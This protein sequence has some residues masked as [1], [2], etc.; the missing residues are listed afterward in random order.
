MTEDVGFFIGYQTGVDKD[1]LKADLEALAAPQDI[2][3]KR[4]YDDQRTFLGRTTQGTYEALFGVTLYHDRKDGWKAR[5]PETIPPSL[6][7]KIQTVY[8]DFKFQF[9]SGGTST[10]NL[11]RL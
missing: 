6:L 10:N 4:D 8:V 11:R 5:S 3:W 7:A 1:A 2:E 9:T